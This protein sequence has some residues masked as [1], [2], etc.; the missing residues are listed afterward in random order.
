[1]MHVRSARTN[2]TEQVESDLPKGSNQDTKHN[3]ADVAEDL[4]IGRRNAK[5]PRCQEGDDSIAG[6]RRPCQF[7]FLL[8]SCKY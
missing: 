7:R 3:D 4:E 2:E 8:F 6:L 1:M 5:S